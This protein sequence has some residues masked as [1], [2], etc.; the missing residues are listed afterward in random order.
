[1]AWTKTRYWDDKSTQGKWKCQT[2]DHRINTTRAFI[3][4]ANSLWITL[5]NRDTTCGIF[6]LMKQLLS[7][8]CELSLDHSQKQKRQVVFFSWWRT[9]LVHVA[10]S[11]WIGLKNRETSSGIL[12]LMKNLL[13]PCCELSVDRSEKQRDFKWYSSVDEELA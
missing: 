8:C 5:K 7:R 1:M 11:L 12:Q 2:R 9:C 4:V 13:S 3:D 10:N 6:Q